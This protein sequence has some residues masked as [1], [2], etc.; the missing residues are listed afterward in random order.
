MKT[1]KDF[2]YKFI[3]FVVDNQKVVKVVKDWKNPTNLNIDIDY[4]MR[5]LNEFK[6][7]NIN[8]AKNLIVDLENVSN[9]DDLEDF[10]TK[11][12]SIL[13]RE[14]SLDN[15]DEVIEG[16]ELLE[17]EK[18]VALEVSKNS[19]IF[20]YLDETL[21]KNPYFLSELVKYDYKLARNFEDTLKENKEALIL[22]AKTNFKMFNYLHR[23]ES[24]LYSFRDDFEVAKALQEALEKEI[25]D[26][27]LKLEDI[28]IFE[29][30]F[31]FKNNFPRQIFMTCVHFE[32]SFNKK[33]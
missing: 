32:N 8:E 33:A 1:Y 29:H 2:L 15:I 25:I 19:F 16:R 4:F 24:L 18:K 23:Q 20:D 31:R 7:F 12:L 13:N 30:D 22:C 26:N 14:L 5:Y 10:I 11:L 27:N 6:I 3:Q 28:F 17:E 21:K 9:Y